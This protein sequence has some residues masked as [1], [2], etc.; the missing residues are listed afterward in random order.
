MMINFIITLLLTFLKICAIESKSTAVWVDDGIGTTVKAVLSSGEANALKTYMLD[1]F[2]LPPPLKSKKHHHTTINGSAPTYLKSIFDALDERGQAPQLDPEHR[3]TVG[4]ADIIITFVNRNSRLHN[5][6]DSHRRLMFNLEDVPLA[7][8][9]LGAELRV[10]KTAPIKYLGKDL[11]LHVYLGS[12]VKSEEREIAKAILPEKGWTSLN[13]T[14][15]ALSWI[16]F[17]ESNF[18]LRLSVTRPGKKH[19]LH[20]TEVGLA[21]GHA[22]EDVRPFIVAFFALP[23]RRKTPY[24]KRVIRSAMPKNDLKNPY[25]AGSLGIDPPKESQCQKRPLHVSFKDLG[26]QEWVIA[27]EGYDA[28]FCDG[29]CHFPL[30]AGMNATNHAIIQT[31]VKMKKAYSDDGMPPPDA[32]CAPRDLSTISV[33]Y[34]DYSNNVVLKKY[35]KMIVKTCGCI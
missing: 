14:S 22:S 10:F 33:L 3:E 27:P 24:H 12:K 8:S 15:A 26:W 16:L 28:N 13:V 9:L 21:G 29:R 5:F 25:V 18:G 30:L 11:V 32:C 2:G 6:L 19:E 4:A 34:Y 23:D 31:L 17:P 20:L 35:P 7:D 1:V